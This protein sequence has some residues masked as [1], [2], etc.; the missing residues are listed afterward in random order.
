MALQLYTKNFRFK[1]G[2][3]KRVRGKLQKLRSLRHSAQAA[4][5]LSSSELASAWTS[6]F[7]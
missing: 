6:T 3:Q 7:T 1:S 2:I 4:Q 5:D